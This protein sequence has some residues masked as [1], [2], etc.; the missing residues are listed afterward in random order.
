MNEEKTNQDSDADSDE[1]D[2]WSRCPCCGK[3]MKNMLLH[4][5]KS[6]VCC[7]HV[8]EEDHK[9][10]IEQSKL[11]RKMKKKQWESERKMKDSYKVKAGQRVRTFKSRSLAVQKEYKLDQERQLPSQS[12]KSNE[13]MEE[14]N[15]RCPVCKKKCKNV[16]LHVKKRRLC[17]DRIKQDNLEKLLKESDEQRMK[18]QERAVGKRKKLQEGR[19]K[20]QKFVHGNEKDS[21]DDEDEVQV[22]I[23]EMCPNCN[24]K[25]KNILLHIQCTDMCYKMIDKQDFQE[26]RKMAQKE[27]KRKYQLKFNERGG[28]NK[29]R[30]IRREEEY[31]RKEFEA[32][33][34][35]HKE[36]VKW[37]KSLFIHLSGEILMYLSIGKIPD[38][39]FNSVRD[40]LI[41]S[42]YST[43]KDGI[44]TYKSLLNEE[45]EHAWVKEIKGQFLEAVIAFQIV[46][47]I[48]RSNWENAVKTVKEAGREELGNKLFKLIGNL[49]ANN[50][51]DQRMWDGK[52]H[53]R[54]GFEVAIPEKFRS[55]CN[56]S[57]ST[58]WEG[59]YNCWQHE[60]FCQEDENLLIK[61]IENI[62]GEHLHLIDEE[63]QELLKVKEDMENLY[64]AMAFAA[65]VSKLKSILE[66][67][68][69]NAKKGRKHVV[70]RCQ[71]K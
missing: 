32:T 70:I 11:R 43:Y 37:K 26:W 15:R 44:Y 6:V 67:N 46:I 40:Q 41:Q 21:E 68:I 50:T 4:L 56:Q 47:L 45:E 1:E 60:I 71:C 62:L 10:I 66:L 55:I 54:M 9:K 38:L 17:N 69:P 52:E 5:K 57:E 14:E 27:S 65:P 58:R 30:S 19:K 35:F 20:N 63:V 61:Y 64:V 51:G 53:A 7:A 31:E 28:H 59:N 39:A 24:I 18:R 25:K 3:K 13:S 49:Q 33:R 22:K 34:R 48:P 23:P 16:L 12:V 2:D 36:R 29:A 8:N 42:D